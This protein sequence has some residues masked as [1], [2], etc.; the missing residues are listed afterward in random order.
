MINDRVSECPIRRRATP[1]SCFSINIYRLVTY[2]R[3]TAELLSIPLRHI[4][5]ILLMSVR[6]GQVVGGCREVHGVAA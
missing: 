5:V 1:Y 4:V 3:R 2:Y 6:H